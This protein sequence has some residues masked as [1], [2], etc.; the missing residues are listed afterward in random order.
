MKDLLNGNIPEPKSFRKANNPTHPEYE[1][2]KEAMQREINTLM[3]K[4]TWTLVPKKNYSKIPV[5]CK[6]VYKKKFNKDESLQYKARLV[7]CGYSQVAGVDYSIDEVYAGVCSYSSMRF[8]MS[9]ACQ[10]NYILYQTDITGAYLEST[11]KEKVYMDAPP[12]LWVD[13]KPPMDENGNE[14]ICEVSK[15][16]YGLVNSGHAWSECFKEFL[17]KDKHYNMGFTEL[18]GEP[19]MYRQSYTINGK[20]EELIIGQYVDDC[21]IA[22]SSQQILDEFMKKLKARF[23]VNDKSSGEI[24]VDDPG[25]LLSMQVKYDKQNGVLQF[26]QERAIETLAHK[27][28]VTEDYPRKLPIRSPCELPKIDSPDCAYAIGVL[29]RHSATPGQIHME[30]AKDLVRYMYNTKNLC[31]Q[32]TRSTNV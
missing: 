25:L 29:S 24:S 30:A 28:Q 23:P 12:N 17:L 15:G 10:K 5:K 18:T 13:G 27:I 2:W 4:N 6:F 9:L 1:Q 16:L 14:L 19:N 8:L 26:N 21:L 32:Y 31:I 22:A 3:Q 7:G 11:L 20:E